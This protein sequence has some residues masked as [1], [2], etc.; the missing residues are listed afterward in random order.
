MPSEHLGHYICLLLCLLKMLLL[1]LHRCAPVNRSIL[2]R[3]WVHSGVLLMR[4]SRG[5]HAASL[6]QL[7]R[8]LHLL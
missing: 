7:L 2:C 5:H 3:P 6:L 1:L 4:L 8:L